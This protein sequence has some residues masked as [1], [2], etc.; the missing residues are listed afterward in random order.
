MLRRTSLRGFIYRF[1][2][3]GIPR[4]LETNFSWGLRKL[5]MAIIA[6]V[7]F[8]GV[9]LFLTLQLDAES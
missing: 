1:T 5:N 4:H 2:C 3:Q 6:I 8:V 7:F 9:V